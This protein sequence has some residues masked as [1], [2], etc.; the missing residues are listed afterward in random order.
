MVFPEGQDARAYEGCIVECNWLEEECVWEFARTRGDKPMPNAYHVYES[1]MRSIHDKITEE[2]LLAEAQAALQLPIYEHD[3][4]A[5]QKAA[6]APCS[7]ALLEE[8]I[9]ICRSADLASVAFQ[10]YVDAAVSTIGLHEPTSNLLVDAFHAY[11]HTEHAL[12]QNE[13]CRVLAAS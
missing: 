13:P 12:V 2:D 10:G 5:V 3:A 4:A 8:A 7:R 6:A 1:V 11:H 9:P